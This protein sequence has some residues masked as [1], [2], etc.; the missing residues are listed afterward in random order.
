MVSHSSDAQSF[1]PPS[2]FNLD[3]GLFFLWI[4]TVYSVNF[5][6]CSNFFAGLDGTHWE[7]GS[8]TPPSANSLKGLQILHTLQLYPTN[9]KQYSVSLITFWRLFL[10]KVLQLQWRMHYT[11]H[12]WSCI[13]QRPLSLHTSSS[14]VRELQSR[15]VIPMCPPQNTPSKKHKLY[16]SQKILSP[17]L[18][19]R[20][21][22]L[23]FL[24]ILMDYI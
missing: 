1:T 14:N 4:L 23:I 20:F 11:C 9:T 19:V 12:A 3:H 15:Y 18:H 6:P 10:K 21:F 17:P 24:V 13:W 2:T 8:S 5:L 16:I 7:E 22:F